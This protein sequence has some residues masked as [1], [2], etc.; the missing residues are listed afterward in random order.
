MAGVVVLDAGALIALYRGKDAHHE[1][2]KSM[3]IDTVG[4][5]WVMNTLTYAEVLV[6]PIKQRKASQ[7]R[8]GIAGLGIDINS[9]TDEDSVELANIRASSN[10]RMP[11]AVVLFEAIRSKA[12]LATTDDSLARE[13]L[14]RGL[15]VMCPQ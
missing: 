3:F 9:L 5:E 1:W 13:A 10:L 4:D 12:S 11:D 8:K 7:F 14:R 6:H 2:A 15:R